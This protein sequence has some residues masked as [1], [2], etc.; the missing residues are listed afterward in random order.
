M[1]FMYTRNKR[2][3]RTDPRDTPFWPWT[4]FWIRVG[5]PLNKLLCLKS[6][7]CRLT[8]TAPGVGNKMLR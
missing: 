7:T 8:D 5:T 4:L 2:G 1:P 6:N 3:Q